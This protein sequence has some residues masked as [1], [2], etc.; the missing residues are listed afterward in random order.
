[1][2]NFDLEY[3]KLDKT[4]GFYSND[5]VDAGK[6][7]F[8]G[9]ARAK[10]PSWKGWRI[11]DAHRKKKDFPGCLRNLEELETARKSFYKINYWDPVGGDV[12][13]HQSIAG[14]LF[15]MAVN[16]GVTAAICVT[17]HTVGLNCTSMDKK[18]VDTLNALA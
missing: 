17:A 3:Q 12:L 1:M 15:D 5:K 4:E 10:N 8:R 13:I 2:A 9:I 7:T 11:I 16:K 18:L 14:Q 6:E